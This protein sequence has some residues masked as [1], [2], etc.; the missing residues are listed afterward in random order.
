MD[1]VKFSKVKCKP[2]K[3]KIKEGTTPYSVTTARRVPI[4]LQ[5]KVKKELDRMKE[6]DIIEEVTEPTDWVSPM[7]P[8]PKAKGEVRI[9]VD[10]RKLNQAIQRE[11]Y[12][13][14]TFDDIIHELRGSTIFSKLDAQSGF[15]Q[16]PLDPET[17]KLTTFI[18]P[19]G[20]FF[21][22]RLP[23]GISSAPE[24]FM[25]VVSDIIE[26]ING[27]ICYFDDILC[28]PKTK[29]DH[30]KLLTLVHRRLEEAGLQL[31]K[32]KCVYRKRNRKHVMFCPNHNHPEDEPVSNTVLDEQLLEFSAVPEP[33]FEASENL[34][35]EAG[36]PTSPG[37]T[38]PSPSSSAIRGAQDKTPLPY[39]T[40]S[41]R[42]VNK[43][44]RF[45]E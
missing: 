23:F 44:P 43:P 10:L 38:R 36:P 21:M 12:I 1:Q 35:N 45:C 11:K 27:V 29:E 41:G 22:K 4:P 13:I 8:V 20:R 39:V 34:Q 24:I 9:C 30:E 40:R 3:I 37:P 14:P 32:E 26:G 25:R 42:A 18:T 6:L 31:N 5:S 17:S 2:V 19:Y 15:W 33:Q 16:I 28:H 7:V